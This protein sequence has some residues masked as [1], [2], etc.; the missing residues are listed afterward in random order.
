[1]GK[2]EI[3]VR[4]EQ[5]IKDILW[6]TYGVTPEQAGSFQLYYSVSAATKEIL[7]DKYYRFKQEA[8][9]QSAKRI[10]YLSMEFLIGRSLKNNLFNLGILDEVSEF[11][12]EC[13]FSPEEIFSQ[14]KDAGLGNGGL[15]RLAACYLDALATSSYNGEGYSILYEYGIF[16]QY[17]KDGEQM[18]LPDTWLDSG[19]VWLSKNNHKKFVI[20][21]GGKINSD[22]TQRKYEGYSEVI[23]EGYDMHIPGYRSNGVSLLKLWKAIPSDRFDMSLLKD[24]D[25][26]SILERRSGAE[27]I[28]MFLYPPDN[29]EKGKKLRLL[30]QY[31]FVSA[32]VQNV[33]SEHYK[34]FKSVD[35][36][37][38]HVSFHIND[39]HPALCIP[40]L[41]R[42]LSEDYGVDFDRAA[43]ITKNCV[44]YTNHTVMPEALEVWDEKLVKELIPRVHSVIKELNRMMSSDIYSMDAA[45]WERISDI[46]IISGGNVRMANMSVHYSHKVNGVSGLHSQIIKDKVFY[47]FAQKNPEKF[48]NVTNAITY[49][50]WLCQA[51]PKLAELIDSTIG[52]EYRERPYELI[53]FSKHA[54]EREVTDAFEEIRYE[55]KRRLSNLSK[56][57]LDESLD[58]DSMFDVQIK[59]LHEYK[60]QLLNVLKIMSYYIELKNNPNA[61]IS[62]KTFIFGAKAAPSY[63]HAKRIIKLINKLSELIKNDSKV[64]DVLGVVFLPDYNVSLAEM[65]I[66]AA[67]IS[68]QI[69][70]AGKEA[71]GTG[72]MKFMLNGALTLGTYDGANVEICELAGEG[73]EYIFGMRVD[74]VE[75]LREKEYNADLIVDSDPRL[76]EVIGLLKSSICGED[77]SDIAY[78]LTNKTNPDPYFCLYDYASYM[79]CYRK[80]CIDYNNKRKFFSKAIINVGNAPYFASDRAIEEYAEKIWSASRVKTEKKI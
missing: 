48:I 41:I 59:R 21:I 56:K 2:S 50:R 64:K 72:N 46:S 1:M 16:K 60:R 34:S 13:S 5:S 9:R 63:T 65:I 3:M 47:E 53:N 18:E 32:T 62:P 79:Q 10:C 36:L 68:E 77:F 40:E 6:R 27:L 11:I 24:G 31:F 42:V 14:E 80:A 70:L 12:S 15:G 17:F 49:R 22:G 45:S 26:D 4:M 73:N 28:S 38:D 44:S 71:S 37:S 19:E 30:Q 25:F 75:E 54:N 67:D 78:Y 66:P 52:D 58:P 20:K 39:T 51:N 55:N 74:E 35:N 29:T 61:D 23:A 8:N 43:E 76:A 7:A 69:S 57:L 33:V